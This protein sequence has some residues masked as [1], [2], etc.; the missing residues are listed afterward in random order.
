MF[1]L[2]HDGRKRKQKKK[3]K[4]EIA[5]GLFSLGSDMPC[6]L[7]CT[8]FLWLL[9]EIEGGLNGQSLNFMCT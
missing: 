4:K 8:G 7:C 6:W 3:K 1:C 2:L 9:G 5:T